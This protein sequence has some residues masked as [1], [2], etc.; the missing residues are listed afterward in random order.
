VTS[1][2]SHFVGRSPTGR[3]TPM[4]M[5]TAS[6]RTLGRLRSDGSPSPKRRRSL[7]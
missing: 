1:A 5:R 4:G 3:G 7:L 2:Q 6:R